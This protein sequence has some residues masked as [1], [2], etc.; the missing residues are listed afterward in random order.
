MIMNEHTD[1]NSGQS[2][3]EDSEIVTAI[4][5]RLHAHRHVW[6]D[7]SGE[8]CYHYYM[9]SLGEG[10]GGGDTFLSTSISSLTER[11]VLAVHILITSDDSLIYR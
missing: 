4:F 7:S 2:D 3:F 8:V 1:N 10:E 6:D 9:R 11:G 5:D